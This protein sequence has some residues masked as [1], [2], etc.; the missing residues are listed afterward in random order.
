MSKFR[1]SLPLKIAEFRQSVLKLQQELANLRTDFKLTGI[2]PA[3][4]HMLLEIKKIQPT[5]VVNLTKVLGLD[6]STVSQ[7]LAQMQK[8]NW[9]ELRENPRDRRY[10]IIELTESGE[11]RCS[12]IEDSYDEQFEE[13]LLRLAEQERNAIAFGVGSFAYLLEKRRHSDV[14]D[15]LTHEASQVDLRSLDPSGK[16]ME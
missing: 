16:D 3:Q 8:S 2:T 9:V 12:E 10:K 5:S 13:I 1:M 6:K 4:G 14:D 11:Q 7:T 15:G